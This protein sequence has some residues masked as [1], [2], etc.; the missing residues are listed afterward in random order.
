MRSRRLPSILLDGVILVLVALWLMGG[1]TW[2]GRRIL[3]HGADPRRA[4]LLLGLVAAWAS[5]ALRDQSLWIRGARAFWKGLCTRRGRWI[6]L[7]L[8]CALGS[9]IGALQALALQV[10]QYDV[11]IFHQIIWAVAHGHGFLSTISGAGNFLLDHLSPTLALVV[12]L[13]WISGDSPLVLPVLQPL[14]VFGGVAAWVWLAEQLEEGAGMPLAAAAALFGICFDSLWGSLHWGFHENAIAF[15]SLSWAYA[16]IFSGRAA[17]PGASLRGRLGAGLLLVLAAASKEILLLDVA[18]ALGLWGWR[19]GNRA[20]LAR[21]LAMAALL[22]AVFVWFEKIP[23]PADKN[24]FDRYYS[25][26]GHGLGQFART[27]VL[28]PWKVVQNVGAWELVRYFLI[29]FLP[30]LGL[31]L[32]ALARDRRS[33][34]WIL[35]ALPSLASAALSTDISLRRPSFH[36]VL[37]LWPILAAITLLQLARLRSARFA[38]A[39]ALWAVLAWDHDPIGAL[40]QYSREAAAQSEARGFL[41]A[42]PSEAS[43]S[44]DELAGTW[45]ANRRLVT[46][47]AALAPFEGRCP[48]WIV[49]RGPEAFAGV[50]HAACNGRMRKER[51]I[52]DWKVWRRE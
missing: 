52:G 26:L 45:V 19:E 35:A 49:V 41:A 43:V 23:H 18:L 22:I 38:V 50:E 51:E 31:P 8:A 6:A 7:A 40:R 11:G 2:A 30:W 34:A 48:D 47:W 25:Y 20:A 44:A 13:F 42:L 17:G 14:L 46:R 12:P 24:Y 16:L 4:A 3:S 10:P 37:E 29:V 21:R 5:P 1:T 28:S 32:Y 39:W 33:G 9:V 36:Y 27:L 15:V